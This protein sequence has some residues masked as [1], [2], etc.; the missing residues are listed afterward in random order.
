MSSIVK[1]RF[2]FFKQVCRVCRQVVWLQFFY[3]IPE[4]YKRAHGLGWLRN[5][6][7]CAKCHR[8]AKTKSGECYECRSYS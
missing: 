7:H 1:K 6:L 5:E 2:A 3:V 4:R 8:M